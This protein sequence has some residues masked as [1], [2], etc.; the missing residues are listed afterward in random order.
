MEVYVCI[1]EE[2]GKRGTTTVRIELDALRKARMCFLVED[3]KTESNA[4]R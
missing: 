2:E 4:Q 1:D 3:S